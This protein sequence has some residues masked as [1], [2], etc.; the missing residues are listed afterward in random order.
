MKAKRKSLL[1]HLW[2]SRRDT[3]LMLWP[4]QE[5]EEEQ[6]TAAVRGKLKGLREALFLEVD[7]SCSLAERMA[8]ANCQ[9]FD[10]GLA[11]EAFHN[12]GMCLIPQYVSLSVDR[13]RACCHPVTLI[14]K[15][16]RQG[17]ERE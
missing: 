5:D 4:L 13:S 14:E 8:Q 15:R 9:E 1:G 7:N 3:C 2:P 6:E 17:H 16:D 10:L 11:G 12:V